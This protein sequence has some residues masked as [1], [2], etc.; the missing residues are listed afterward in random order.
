MVFIVFEGLNGSGKSSLAKALALSLRGQ[1][2]ATPPKEIAP[3]RAIMDEASL[4]AHFFYY[5]LGNILISDELK[6]SKPTDIIICDRYVDS[7]LARHAVLGL[8]IRGFDLGR[9]ALQEPDISFFIYC[10]ETERLRRVEQRGKKNKWDIL[11]EDSR[12][13]KKYIEYFRLKK[14]FH[15]FNTSHETE[16]ESLARLI[17]VLEKKGIILKK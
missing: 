8:D 14:K 7:T 17:S 13:R 2:I 10:D 12:L 6:K 9:F 15:F 3:F 16:S 4:T 11:D 1:Y 5:M